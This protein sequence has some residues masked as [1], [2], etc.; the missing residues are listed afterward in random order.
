MG[1]REGG[2]GSPQIGGACEVASEVPDHGGQRDR[3]S[4]QVDAGAATL[5]KFVDRGCPISAPAGTGMRDRH[6]QRGQ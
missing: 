6:I 1:S 5:R 2:P 4:G 3:I